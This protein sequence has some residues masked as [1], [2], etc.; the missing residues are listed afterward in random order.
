[1]PWPLA[2]LGAGLAAVPVGAMV[3]IPAIRLSGLYLAL[4]TFGFGILVERLGFTTGLMFGK[5]GARVGSPSPRTP[6]RA[7]TSPA[8]G[9]FYYV[10]LGVVV[11][12][13][14]AVWAVDRTRLA[15]SCRGWP[16]PRVALT[17]QGATVNIT[18]VLVFALSA[19][20]AGVGRSAVRRPLRIDQRNTVSTPLQSL[21]WLAGAGDRRIRPVL[22]RLRGR[23]AAGPSCRRT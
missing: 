9:G 11:L 4:A 10:V 22:G 16:D 1:V 17:T 21:L 6:P 3:A 15:G 19:A 13:V 14:L 20:L 5:I 2:V 18:R 23:R 7:S 12:G 8:I